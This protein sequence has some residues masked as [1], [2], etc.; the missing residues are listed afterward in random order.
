[1]CF[2]DLGI[3]QVLLEPREIGSFTP[4]LVLLNVLV[5]EILEMRCCYN[6]WVLYDFTDALCLSDCD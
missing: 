4:F 5:L 2:V 1:M 3:G 6:T